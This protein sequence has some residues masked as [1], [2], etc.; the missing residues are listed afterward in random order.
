MSPSGLPTRIE[1][2]MSVTNAPR[3]ATC[4]YH[5]KRLHHRLG[6]RR[7]HALQR[8]RLVEEHLVLD[9]IAEIDRVQALDVL[10]RQDE[11]HDVLIAHGA[12]ERIEHDQAVNAAILVD[13]VD[14]PVER[15][16]IGGF[17]RPRRESRG[18]GVLHDEIRDTAPM[19]RPTPGYRAASRDTA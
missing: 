17:E 11:I 8:P 19:P 15:V 14:A 7:D 5:C 2:L 12:L 10:V 13:F 1:L 18:G 4:G 16:G 3:I 6:R 9:E